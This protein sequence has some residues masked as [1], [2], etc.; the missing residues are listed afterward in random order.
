MVPVTT[1]QLFSDDI[2]D[3]LFGSTYAPFNFTWHDPNESHP[4]GIPEWGTS[5]QTTRG[6][7]RARSPADIAAALAEVHS[8]RGSGHLVTANLWRI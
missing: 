8:T 4:P 1:K 6:Q 7:A 3:T 5:A 2:L